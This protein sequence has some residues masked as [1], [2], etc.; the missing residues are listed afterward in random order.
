MPLS[1]ETLRNY[2]YVNTN[3]ECLETF[4]PSP[5]VEHWMGQRKRRPKSSDLSRHQEWYTGVF[6]EADL[7]KHRQHNFKI[8]F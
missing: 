3:M 2:L 7:T 1:A 5:A 8:E 6:E 4:D